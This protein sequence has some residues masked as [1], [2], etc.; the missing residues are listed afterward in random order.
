MSPCMCFQVPTLVVFAHSLQIFR[1]QGHH[2]LPIEQWRQLPRWD[3]QARIRHQLRTWVSLQGPGEHGNPLL[4]P[5][6]A[7]FGNDMIHLK[8]LSASLNAHETDMV[9]NMSH[10]LREYSPLA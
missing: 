2:G 1:L 3:A 8:L 6:Q 7:D 10:W 5:L 4:P 9:K